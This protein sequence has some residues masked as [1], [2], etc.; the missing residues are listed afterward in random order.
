MFSVVGTTADDAHRPRFQQSEIAR[1]APG[2]PP[3]RPAMSSF[4]SRSMPSAGLD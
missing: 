2:Q 1:I 4:N 3:P